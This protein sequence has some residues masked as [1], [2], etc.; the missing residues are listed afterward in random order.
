MTIETTFAIAAT[1]AA[2]WQALWSELGLGEDGTFSVEGSTWPSRLQLK[3]PLAGIPC[4]LTY[5]IEPAEGGSEVT[6][7]LDPT[8]FRFVVSQLFTLG[9]FGQHY[10]MMLAAGLSNLKTAVEG[11]DDSADPP[12]VADA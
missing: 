12:A 1:P 4:F 6:A 3:M 8:G 2:I 11:P 7:S 5:R 9:H 10:K